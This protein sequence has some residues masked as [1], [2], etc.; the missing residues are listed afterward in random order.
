MEKAIKD[1]GIL[2]GQV[3]DLKGWDSSVT[4]L[5]EFNGIPHL[6]LVDEEG[7]IVAKN[8]RGEALRAKVAE[9]CGSSRK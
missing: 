5:Y 8:L 3:S 1:D 7:R 2:W 9:I 6:L 4:K